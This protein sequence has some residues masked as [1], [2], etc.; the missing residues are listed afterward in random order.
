MFYID[1]TF[2]RPKPLQ[3]LKY[4]GTSRCLTPAVSLRRFPITELEGAKRFRVRFGNGI[5]TGIRNKIEI[6]EK[7]RK[8]FGFCILQK[9]SESALTLTR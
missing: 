9:N 7:R 4:P 5:G 6:G 1:E 2:F 8:N 3:F